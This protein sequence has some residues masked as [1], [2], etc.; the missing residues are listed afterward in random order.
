MRGVGVRREGEVCGCEGCVRR[1]G[2]KCVR[3]EGEGGG[4]EEGGCEGC[5]ME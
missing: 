5:G 1:E 2:E 4:C 3:R